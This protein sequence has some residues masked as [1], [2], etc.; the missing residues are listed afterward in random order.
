MRLMVSATAQSQN[1]ILLAVSDGRCPFR[2]LWIKIHVLR[3]WL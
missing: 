3:K 1:P 2:F